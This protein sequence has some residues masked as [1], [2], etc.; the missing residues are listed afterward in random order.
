MMAP[1]DRVIIWGVGGEGCL[2]MSSAIV[3]PDQNA[4]NIMSQPVL[5]VLDCIDSWSLLPFLLWPCC[6]LLHQGQGLTSLN[7]NQN[8]LDEYIHR[9]HR[10]NQAN[11]NDTG[12]EYKPNNRQKKS[13]NSVLLKTNHRTRHREEKCFYLTL[14]NQAITKL[15]FHSNE[16]SKD[17]LPII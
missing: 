7:N 3:T 5:M 17:K 11:S 2:C 10:S 1:C 9:P 14:Y 4:S 16:T 13:V 8:G 12:F 15:A 6:I